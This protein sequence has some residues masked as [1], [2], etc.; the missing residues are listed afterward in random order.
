MVSVTSINTTRSEV[1]YAI[2]K[3]L[4]LLR[5][6]PPHTLSFPLLEELCSWARARRCAQVKA[7][8]SKGLRVSC[9]WAVEVVRFI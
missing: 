5:V 4:F 6:T 3:M 1:A 2:I 7:A 8:L 9:G